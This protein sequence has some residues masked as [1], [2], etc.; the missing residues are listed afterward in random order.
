MVAATIERE[1]PGLVAVPSIPNGK[2]ELTR[3]PLGMLRVALAEPGPGYQR[4]PQERQIKKIVERWDWKMLDPLWVSRRIDGAN[5][6]EFFV[7]DGQHRWLAAQRLFE[8]SQ[9]LPVLLI[10]ATFEQEAERF[11]R[12]HENERKVSA[13]ALYLARLEARDPET[14]DMKAAVERQGWRLYVPP[15][16]N[17]A[18]AGR[19]TIG[20]ISTVTNVYRKYGDAILG[21]ALKILGEAYQHDAHA[22]DGRLIA[23]MAAFLVSFPEANS[24]E[25]I[26]RLMRPENTPR[27][28]L[29]GSGLY[30]SSHQVQFA[31]ARYLMDVYN[32]HRSVKRLNWD[33]KSSIAKGKAG[34]ARGEK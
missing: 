34:K 27:R 6:G 16:G 11:A 2:P 22:A 8:D 18:R 7:V 12:Q 21:M 29:Q 10:H 28:I 9:E 33:K 4:A 24:G 32:K 23:G 19:G 20:A 15:S 26:D 13:N 31:V 5:A 30:I 25:L 17:P 3:L 1:K 14:L